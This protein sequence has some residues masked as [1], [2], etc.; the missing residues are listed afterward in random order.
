MRKEE[1]VESSIV[2]AVECLPNSSLL[3]ARTSNRKVC[4]TRIATKIFRGTV[5]LRICVS[6]VV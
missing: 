4:A 3:A 5:Y 1:S 6:M 2:S